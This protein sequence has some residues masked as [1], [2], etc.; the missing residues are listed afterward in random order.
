MPTLDISEAAGARQSEA[1]AD[2]ILDSHERVVGRPLL[3]LDGNEAER[4]LALYEANIA[5][6][7]HGL[8][9]D[10]VFTYGNR[11]AQQLFELSWSELVRLPSR[12]SAEPVHRDERQR[13]L[14]AVSTRGY[15]ADY[16][17]VRISKSGR[18]FRIACATVWNLTDAAGALHG[19]AAAFASWTEVP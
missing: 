2:L 9:S 16:S 6:L 1:L 4:A 7:S 11:L 5:V 15:I 17:G 14:D 13:L 10:P 3:A 18:R 19:Q 12:L 8:G